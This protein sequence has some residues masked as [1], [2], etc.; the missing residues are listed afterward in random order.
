[1]IASTEKKT[2]G[3][4]AHQRI[5]FQRKSFGLMKLHHVKPQVSTNGNPARSLKKAHKI[6]Y[7]N[8]VQ[9]Q[10]PYFYK[11]LSY[12]IKSAV[13]LEETCQRN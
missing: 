3:N 2:G 12:Y 1:M 5:K 4:E 11:D 8:D 13:L 6:E 9:T 10:K 7:I